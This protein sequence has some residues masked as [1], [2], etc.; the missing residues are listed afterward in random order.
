[1]SRQ[2][3]FDRLRVACQELDKVYPTPWGG[4]WTSNLE[5][6]AVAGVDR[7]KSVSQ[8]PLV[9]FFGVLMIVVTLVL[10]IACANVASLLLARAAS[11]GQELGIR[12]AI[13]AGRGRLVRQLLAESLL[14]ALLGAVAGLALNIWLTRL[15]S[16][17]SLP[18][19]IPVQL[20]I[21]PDWRLLS[22]A[23]ALALASAFFCGLLPALKATRTDVNT[24]LKLHEHQASGRRWSFRNALVVGQLAVSI[25][26]LAAGFLFLRNLVRSTS[27]NPGFDVERTAWAEMRLVPDQYASPDRI[28]ARAA[29]AL[30]L[31]QTLPGVESA[32]L[33]RV[34]PFNGAN[35]RG[36]E[37]RFDGKEQAIRV[38]YRYN[39]VGPAYF[40]TMGI[41]ILQG[42]EFLPSDRAGSPPVVIVNE[43][44]ARR[45]FGSGGAAGHTIAV[46]G[47]GIKTIVGV[48]RNSKYF[49]LGEDD[50][51]ALYEPY[52]QQQSREVILNLLFRTPGPPDSLLRPVT[53]VLT[54]LDPAAAVQIKPMRNAMGLALLPSQ[55]GGAILGTMG[56]LGLVLAS[57]GLYGVLVYAVS[58][59][60]R[61]IGI[62]L[63]LGATSGDILRMLFRES[64][65]LVGIGMAIGLGIAAFA[66]RPLAMFLVPGLSPTD[67]TAF[68]GV[69]VVLAVV[70][71]LATAGPARRALRVDPL[72]ALRY[73]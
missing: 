43:N 16:R 52:F 47:A 60:L 21:A 68:L 70:A 30:E 32:S 5:V 69:V 20:H 7:L 49:T 18:L 45:Y 29:T 50:V 59:R 54:T 66:T 22:Y 23:S 44:F 46:S 10:L 17:I 71:A 35:T 65:L 13:G 24:A 40:R 42:R 63:A 64:F 9:A 48:A 38:N 36:G 19:P 6:A 73:E 28:A 12:L 39:Q 11:R 53:T 4:S 1:M 3:A 41:P 31:I 14:L 67:P 57:L 34:V 27:M 25:L 55:V 56:V 33:A 51:S 72:T 15:M 37:A 61:E 58:R 26:L 62:R 2:V 8:M